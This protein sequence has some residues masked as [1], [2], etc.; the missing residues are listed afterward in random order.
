MLNQAA[1][2]GI[3]LYFAVQSRHT[4]LAFAMVEQLGPKGR[5]CREIVGLGEVNHVF[6]VDTPDGKWV[7]RF[8]RDPLEVDNYEKEA[9]CLCAMPTVGVPVPEFIGRGTVDGVSFIAQ[10]FV[11]GENAN[12]FR[13]HDLWSTLGR[14]CRAI[15][16]LTLGDSAPDSLFPRFGRDLKANWRQHI[17]YNLSQLTPDDPLLSLGAYELK[18]QDLLR[19][20]FSNLG[21]QIDRFG[22]THGDLVPRNVLVSP[23]NQPVVLDWGSAF[24]GPSP[25]AD[26]NRIWSDPGTEQFSYQELASFAEGY[27]SSLESMLGAMQDLKLL[28]RID[29]IRWAI[30]RRPD[31]IIELVAKAKQATFRLI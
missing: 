16:E 17:E 22:L 31:R 23:G 28:D 10:S 9:W 13:C 21:E 5:S 8:H 1:R 18:H 12:D 29:V 24:T 4:D 27:G 15:G 14:Y 19:A 3:G 20:S 30:D 2:R 11:E 6:V 26:Y 7:I 25:Y